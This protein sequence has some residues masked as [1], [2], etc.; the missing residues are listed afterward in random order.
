MTWRKQD[1]DF[2]ANGKIVIA[3]RRHGFA[4]GVLAQILLDVNASKERGGLLSSLESSPEFLASRLSALVNHTEA[5]VSDLLDGLVAV[6]FLKMEED[7]RLRIP[8]WNQYEWG[9]RS[10]K[11]TASGETRDC[12]QCGEPFVPKADHHHHC[13]PACKQKSYRDRQRDEGDAGVT[14]VTHPR[15]AGV[16]GVT[17]D[18]PE[19][20][21]QTEG[22]R[23][24]PVPAA[25]PPLPEMIRDLAAR[26]GGAPPD[27]LVGVL[28][29]LEIATDAR[30]EATAKTAE[31]AQAFARAGGG[32]DDL[33]LLWRYCQKRGRSSPRGMLVKLLPR[34]ASWRPAVDSERA[35]SA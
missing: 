13:T 35:V 34:E 15:D 30:G 3:V 6:D 11:G 17:N 9:V 16:T 12:A 2:W 8:G 20:I 31:L 32:R 21:D 24:R 23:D 14:G 18:R 28:V 7:G 29:G 10:G 5:E 19:Q 4:A 27:G 26:S 22:Q 1:C 33:L 25:S